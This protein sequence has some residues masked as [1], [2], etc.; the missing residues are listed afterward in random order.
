MQYDL[1]AFNMNISYQLFEKS[2]LC[3][4]DSSTGTNFHVFYLLLQAPPDLKK[5]LYLTR[6]KFAVRIYFQYV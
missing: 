4:R 2:R 5:K 1:G 3:V 6:D